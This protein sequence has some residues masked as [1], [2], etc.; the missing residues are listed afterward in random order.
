MLITSLLVPSAI[1]VVRFSFSISICQL[2]T[3][4]TGK[5]A[6][7]LEFVWSKFCSFALTIFVLAIGS[8]LLA[9][10][11]PLGIMYE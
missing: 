5:S 3:C 10:L 4:A 8:S 9:L 11:S 7:L 2:V 6:N 1:L